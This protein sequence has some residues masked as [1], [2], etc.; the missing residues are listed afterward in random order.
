M[1]IINILR[2]R[3]IEVQQAEDSWEFLLP[4]AK[5]ITRTKPVRFDNVI[6]QAGTVNNIEITAE[7]GEDIL[8]P[9]QIEKAVND[10]DRNVD[11]ILS[12]WQNMMDTQIRHVQDGDAVIDDAFFEDFE[13]DRMNVDFV[14]DVKQ[15]EIIL[16]E[17]EQEFVSSLYDESIFVHALEVDS[18][19]G[20]PSRCKLNRNQITCITYTID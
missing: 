3:I 19:C 6:L 8:P 15:N 10:I 7:E 4:S 18:L 20:I 13:I 2:S 17:G 5:D 16:P 11:G 14:N 12:K 9:H 1:E